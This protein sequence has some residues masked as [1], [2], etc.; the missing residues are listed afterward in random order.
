[1]R[2]N[3]FRL[4]DGQRDLQWAQWRGLL[5]DNWERALSSPRN[6]SRPL[7]T[8]TD[9]R[10]CPVLFA[11]CRGLSLSCSTDGFVLSLKALEH[12]QPTRCPEFRCE[13]P[14][15]AHTQYRVG[16]PERPPG[17]TTRTASSSPTPQ[18]GKQG[19]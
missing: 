6:H 18:L 8:G 4:S 9:H 17:R 19:H 16:S 5:I 12:R 11:A 3:R 15:L 1:M 2:K 10:K 14:G 7:R 13:I